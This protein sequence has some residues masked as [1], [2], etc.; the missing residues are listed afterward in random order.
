MCMKRIFILLVGFV[1]TGT[2]FSQSLKVLDTNNVDISGTTYTV[3]GVVSD[4][5][6]YFYAHVQNVSGQSIQTL[7]CQHVVY[8]NG[9]ATNTFCFGPHCYSSDTANFPVTVNAG[10]IDSTFDA[11]IYIASAGIS[12]ITYT[13]WDKNNP[14]DNVSVTVTYDIATSIE[15]NNFSS[16]YL[17]KPYPIPAS[18]YVY[19][20]CNLDKEAQIVIYD[21]TGKTVLKKTINSDQNKIEIPIKGFNPGIYY[22]SLIMDEKK[23]K[24]DKIIIK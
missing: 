11:T 3:N 19:F 5:L 10:Y 24:T 2:L 14:S 21:I 23:I 8:E 9:L 4:G 12:Q 22:Y 17:S 16:N 20:D 6:D 13:F 18:N 15:F 7:V 1:L